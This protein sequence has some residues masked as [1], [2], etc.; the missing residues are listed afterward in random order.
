MT[1]EKM[2]ELKLLDGIR[3]KESVDKEACGGWPDERLELVGLKR[4]QKDSFY[5][6]INKD[7]VPENA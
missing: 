5:I 4:Q 2:R 3:T 1:I 7:Q 6:E